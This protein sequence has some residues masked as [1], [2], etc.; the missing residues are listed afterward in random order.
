MRR[1][2]L[3]AKWGL[4]L[5][6]GTAIAQLPPGPQFPPPGGQPPAFPG[7]PGPAGSPPPL[8]ASPVLPGA[9]GLAAPGQLPPL[10][11]VSPT[12][13]G[14]NTGTM[15]HGVYPPAAPNTRPPG[16]PVA[17]PQEIPLPQPENKMPL[18]AAEVSL[19]RV[20]GGWQLWHGQKVLRDFGDHEADARD[21]ARVYRDLRPTEWVAI[22]GPKPVVEYGLVNGRAA[23]TAGLPAADDP[24]NPA[25]GGGTGL[26]GGPLPGGA[27]PGGRLP[28]PAGAGLGGGFGGPA[29]TGAGAKQVI[30]ID[31]RT[32]RVEP[33]RGVW[34]VRDDDNLLFNFGANKGDADQALAAVRRYGFNRVGVVGSPAP[35]MTYLFAAPD[36]GGLPP[37]APGPLAK[38]QLQAQIDGLNRVGIPVAGLGYVGEMVRFDPRKL[39][40]RKDGAE[41]VVAAGAEVIGRYGPTEGAARDAARTIAD[42]RYNE[43]CR[44]GTAGVTFF[45]TDGKTPTRVP[46]HVQGR[47]F[48]PA[49]LKVRQAPEGCSV[50]E[51]GRHLFTCA[52]AEEGE[53][54][55]R[56][57]KQ[58]QFDQLCHLGP[59]PRVGVSFLAKGR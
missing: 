55:I 40:V 7:Y 44:V 58:Y 34:C 51:N 29:V 37:R 17:R 13:P 8:P 42:G 39:E 48:D 3:L 12:L 1:R 35:V 5:G 24:K 38:A 59:S 15:P 19:K 53:T 23:M 50:T 2:L 43:V 46:F 57:V 41:W 11:P 36:G 32:V 16:N 45:L 9:G 54:L 27:L 20:S 30:P 56:V 18:N 21:A 26:P 22:G 10:R 14:A 31:L 52:S 25:S 33:V 47:R 28:G 49:A 6:T 4:V